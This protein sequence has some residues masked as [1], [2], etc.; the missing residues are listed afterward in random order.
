MGALLSRS[1][2]LDDLEPT[3][4]KEHMERKLEGLRFRLDSSRGIVSSRV[5]ERI[6]GV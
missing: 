2:F 5:E 1:D 6:E 3:D 4:T